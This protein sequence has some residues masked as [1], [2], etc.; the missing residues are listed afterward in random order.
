MKF[1]VNVETRVPVNPAALAIFLASI[2]CLRNGYVWGTEEPKW[3]VRRAR[4]WRRVLWPLYDLLASMSYEVP[5]P[6]ELPVPVGYVL[7]YFGTRFITDP[8]E[9]FVSRRFSPD[10]L[11]AVALHVASQNI[12][13]RFHI[14]ELRTGS[15][16]VVIEDII[17]WLYGALRATAQI[18][19]APS[20]VHDETRA[21]LGQRMRE[22]QPSNDRRACGL[23]SV[24][25][26]SLVHTLGQM[27]ASGMS[28]E[29]QDEARYR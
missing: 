23:V 28:V 26:L 7:D 1:S 15:I 4:R 24:G 12:D 17:D 10:V 20:Q 6:Q 29:G 3:R 9:A 19:D 5:I 14:L 11:T 22:L 16:T 25:S 21:N 18:V 8:R 13:E 27:R 2:V